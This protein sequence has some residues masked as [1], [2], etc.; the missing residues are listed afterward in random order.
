M[1]EPI[2]LEEGVL[3]VYRALLRNP[4]WGIADI[5]GQLDLSQ[6]EVRLRL[7]K[8]VELSLLRTSKTRPEQ[9]CPVSPE[10]GL[11]SILARSQVDLAQRQ[12]AIEDTRV[13]I[14]AV[15]DEFRAQ[16]AR[17]EAIERMEGLEAVR[18]RLEEL[19]HGAESECLSLLQGGRQQPDTLEASRPLDQL[20]LERGVSIRT[21]YQDSVINDPETLGYARWL[22]DL[23]GQSRTVPTL[24]IY[25]VIVDRAVAL[26]P[27]E[28]RDPRQGALQVR[29]PGIVTAL[30][31]LFEVLWESGT[32]FGTAPSHDRH[33][34]S[35][36]ERA[37][38]QILGDGSTDQ[39]AARQLGLSLRTVR[40]RM[41]DLQD[42]LDARSRFQAGVH[43]AKQGWL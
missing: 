9:F 26:V 7:D 37:L 12:R 25:L 10:L 42:R 31:A 36:Q 41:S 16:R 24:P 27:L 18:V 39:G 35:P 2:G 34:L 15:T 40:R 11:N 29:S 1:F 5:A 21:V 33:G 30:V 43:A 22:A 13:A 20:A 6:D 32:P 23:G 4:E 38:L 17:N 19:A 14:A 28:P 8:L 3:E